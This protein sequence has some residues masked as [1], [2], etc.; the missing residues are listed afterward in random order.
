[1]TRAAVLDDL[2]HGVTSLWVTSVRR[3]RRGR[4][5]RG[6]PRRLPRP[7][8][9]RRLV[10]HRP[11][12]RGPRPARRRRRP[13]VGRRQPRPRPVRGCC[14]ARA[15][16]RPCAPRR[17]RA[18]CAHRDGWRAITVDARVLHEAGATDAE[19][20]APWPSPP[21]SPTC[22]TSTRRAS[23][24][25]EAFG[26]LEFRYARDRRP[27]PHHREAAR[28]AAAVGPGRRGLRRRRPRR[29]G[30]APA[31]GHQPA[32]IT[33]RDPWVNMLRTT[34]AALRR[35]R[36]RRRRRHRA[37][38]RRRLGLPDAFARRIARNT[39]S[40]S[41][42]RPTSAGSSTRRAAP[43]TSSRSPTQLA[44]PP[45][46]GS[47]RSSAPAGWARRCAAGLL[48]TGWPRPGERRSATTSPR[49][50]TRS[51]ACEFPTSRAPP[52]PRRP[53]PAPAAER[54]LPRLRYA[55]RLRG[56]ARRRR[57]PWAPAPGR[58]LPA[59]LGHRAAHTARAASPPTC[60][61]P[62]ASAGRGTARRSRCSRRAAR[63]TPARAPPRSPTCVP[64]V[65]S[66]SLVA[67][68]AESSWALPPTRSPA[69]SRRHRRPF[70]SDRLDAPRRRRPDPEVPARPHL[71]PE[72]LAMSAVPDFTAVDLGDGRRRR[73][74]AAARARA[75]R[76]RRRRASTSSRS[77]PG[78]PRRA[79]LPR[80]VPG[81]RRRT[82]A[83]P[84]RRC[85]PT[86]RGRSA[87][88]PGFSTAEESNAFYRRNLAAGQKGLSVAFD[89]RH[90]PRLRLRP[91]AGRRRRRHGR[92]S[93]S[94]RSTTCGSCSTASRWTR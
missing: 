32:M 22:A 15:D 47:R 50:A 33:P 67:G 77:T 68:R 80:H 28:R 21:A 10:G 72:G 58:G 19:E 35:R 78:R 74:R 85:T 29:G 11:A 31:R 56:A 3:H 62:A 69:R 2:E 71:D 52:L 89:L 5:A 65:R 14:P 42:R 82:C 17:P 27:V 18:A 23:R 64:P 73:R 25:A 1:M 40:C 16:R 83:A 76:G 51:P 39:Q 8:A 79:R 9:R 70:L 55:E 61:P 93:R 94:T 44:T 54:A 26:Q 53:A 34:L 87:S 88:T 81:H 37:A 75:R 49:G 48:A 30:A 36:R 86:S 92:A 57:R 6:A 60:S 24:R 12:G 13:R 59:T 46:T 20:L 43:G 7:R 90:A 84:T 66:G 45:G 4:P 41:S 91:P 63:R 38:V